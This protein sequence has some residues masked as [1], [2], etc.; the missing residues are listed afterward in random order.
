M[1]E[2]RVLVLIVVFFMSAVAG[3]QTKSAPCSDPAFRAFDF[4][5]GEWDVA[6][7]DGTPVGTS[8]VEKAMNGCVVLER[9]KGPQGGYE[10]MSMNTFDPATKQWTQRY[11]D[12]G[13]LVAQLSGELRDKKLEYRR[14]FKRPDGTPVMGRM[15]F[16]DLGNEG[17]RQFVERS[18]DGGKTWTTSF[19]YRYKR[20]K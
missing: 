2:K 5:I 9:Y 1:K 15:T 16:F 4:W 12:N 8:S 13:G 6:S 20:R 14:E 19:D 3:A 10:G 11:A 7:V 17:V 18:I